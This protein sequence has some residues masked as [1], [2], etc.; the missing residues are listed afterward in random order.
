VESLSYISHFFKPSWNC[1]V[2]GSQDFIFNKVLWKELVGDWEL[3][4]C[5]AAYIDRQQGLSCQQCQNN[6]R[7]MALAEGI[8]SY[9]GSNETLQKTA[10]RFK[11]RNLKVLEINSAGNLT[12]FL[13]GLRNH[14]LINYPESNIMK[15]QFDDG[16]WDLVIHSDT[17]EH[18][19]DPML[20]LRETQRL[21]RNGGA[22]VFTVPIIVNRM[23]RTRDDL[24]PSYHGDP[25]N[26]LDDYKVFT[27][28]GVDVWTSVLEAGFQSCRFHHLDYPAGIAIEAVK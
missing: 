2:C 25:A 21:L 7:S 13:K 27:E 28:F 11:Y 17:L 6:L 16:I 23:S 5:E 10:R 19:P 9:L 1:P 26:P 14:T 24:K 8:L 22:S 4:E 18:V 3:S 20:G 15:L 12:P